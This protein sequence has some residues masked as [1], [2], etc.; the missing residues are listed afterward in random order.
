MKSKITQEK[1]SLHSA[2]F[3]PR[4]TSEIVLKQYRQKLKALKLK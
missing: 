2:F 3:H 1:V 4:P